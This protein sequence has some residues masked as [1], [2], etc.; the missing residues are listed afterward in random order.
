MLTDPWF[1]EKFGTYLV[2]TPKGRLTRPEVLLAMRWQE[3][4]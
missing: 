3:A 2:G 4:R 1:S